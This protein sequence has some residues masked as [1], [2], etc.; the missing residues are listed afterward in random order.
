M[1]GAVLPPLKNEDLITEKG[2][3][4]YKLIFHGIIGNQKQGRAF[5][6][7]FKETKL[8]LFFRFCLLATTSFIQKSERKKPLSIEASIVSPHIILLKTLEKCNNIFRKV[9]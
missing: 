3:A 8:S 7:T 4:A 9:N 6:G 2:L 1:A 5:S